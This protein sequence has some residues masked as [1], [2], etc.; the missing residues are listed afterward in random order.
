MTVPS[1]GRQ[2]EKQ[3]FQLEQTQTTM[4]LALAQPAM[5]LSLN[6]GAYGGYVRGRGLS[7]GWV[8][9]GGW[10]QGSDRAHLGVRR[11]AFGAGAHSGRERIRGGGGGGGRRPRPEEGGAAGRVLCALSQLPRAGVAERKPSVHTS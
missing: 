7:A 1:R 6:P 10:G 9:W 4:A 5:Q 3:T 11:D 2:G 8:G